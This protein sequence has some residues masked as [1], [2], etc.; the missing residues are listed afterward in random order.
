MFL[1]SCRILPQQAIPDQ[2][3]V[4]GVSPGPTRVRHPSGASFQGRLPGLIHK[5]YTWLK[6]LQGMNTL[7]NRKLRLSVL[8]QSMANVIIL[9]STLLRRYRHNPS[10]NHRQICRQWRKLCLKSFIIF[11]N[12]RKIFLRRFLTTAGRSKTVQWRRRATSFT[13]TSSRTTSARQRR[14]RMKSSDVFI[15][16]FLR[17]C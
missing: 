10:Q 9:F 3:N 14:Q 7:R 6:A 15:Q 5:H 17:H 8:Q 11:S 1:L 13:T 16:L 12:G 4:G 2:S